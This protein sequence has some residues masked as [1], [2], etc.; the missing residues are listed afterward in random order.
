[1]ANALTPSPLCD[2]LPCPSRDCEPSPSMVLLA[3]LLL[4]PPP[5]LT[6]APPWGVGAFFFFPPGGGRRG[7]R[8]I[9]DSVPEMGKGEI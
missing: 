3:V 1:M 2:P 5:L 4:V 6:A 7:R 8:E 9:K